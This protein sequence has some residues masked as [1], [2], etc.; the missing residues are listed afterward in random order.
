MKFVQLLSI[1]ILMII[2]ACSSD[3]VMT[4]E[5]E[6][7]A[8]REL[9]LEIETLATSEPCTDSSDVSFT[10]IGSK[11]CGGPTGYIAYS[12]SIDVDQFLAE[13]ADYTEKQQSFNMK[14][15]VISDCAVENPPAEVRC[16][17]GIPSLGS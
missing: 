4:Q 9:L 10:A 15:G 7:Q 14:W 11:A 8:L 13:V 1:F 16:E 17:N 3:I 12:L 6:A 2:A 5:E